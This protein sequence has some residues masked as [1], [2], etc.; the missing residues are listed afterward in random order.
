MV[1]GRAYGTRHE[2]DLLLISHIAFVGEPPEIIDE[3]K[4]CVATI[5]IDTTTK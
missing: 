4:D 3:I 1:G 2:D 5:R